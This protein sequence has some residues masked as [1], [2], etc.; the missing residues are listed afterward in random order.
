VPDPQR[1]VFPLGTYVQVKHTSQSQTAKGRIML[2]ESVKDGVYHLAHVGDTGTKK[3]GKIQGKFL[4]PIDQSALNIV[5]YNNLIVLDPSLPAAPSALSEVDP[6]ASA[7]PLTPGTVIPER[8]PSL[9]SRLVLG[10]QLIFRRPC[11]AVNQSPL[12]G[13]ARWSPSLKA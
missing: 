7:L 12:M 5:A 4:Q 1:P 8:P 9:L 13:T 6:L 10:D 2:V 11:H 3:K